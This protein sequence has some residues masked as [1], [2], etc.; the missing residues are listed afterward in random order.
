MDVIIKEQ[1]WRM[2]AACVGTDPEVWFPEQ[3]GITPTKTQQ[4]IAKYCTTCPVRAEC[5]EF[6]RTEPYG[7][8]GGR[9]PLSKQDRKK[10]GRARS[11]REGKR[12]VTARGK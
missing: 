3:R 1:P 11:E 10:R 12:R 2:H 7:A 4:A 8:W 5:A 6:G 9:M